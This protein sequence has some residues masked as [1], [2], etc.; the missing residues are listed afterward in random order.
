MSVVDAPAMSQ[1][2]IRQQ[3][4]TTIRIIYYYIFLFLFGKSMCAVANKTCSRLLLCPLK[5]KNN[6]NKTNVVRLLTHCAER[7]DAWEICLLAA[8]I[9]TVI[10]SPIITKR[11]PVCIQFRLIKFGGALK[12]DRGSC[13]GEEMLLVKTKPKYRRSHGFTI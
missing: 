11:V 5:Q 1:M 6:N 7:W 10:R 2:F 3:N 8:I 9:K 12:I 4:K 13:V